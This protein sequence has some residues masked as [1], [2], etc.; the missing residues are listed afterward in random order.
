MDRKKE[1]AD[2][3]IRIQNFLEAA[4]KILKEIKPVDSSNV[5]LFNG[6]PRKPDK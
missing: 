1:I 6:P 3:M 5:V 4:K 2:E